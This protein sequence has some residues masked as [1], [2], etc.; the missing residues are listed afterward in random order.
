MSR[1]WLVTNAIPMFTCRK[2]I[3]MGVF[4]GVFITFI[5]DYFLLH[6]YLIV[7]YPTF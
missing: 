6:D 3:A 2:A 7:Q 4:S 1:L 5:C